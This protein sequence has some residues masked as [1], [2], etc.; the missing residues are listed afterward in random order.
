MIISSIINPSCPIPKLSGGESTVGGGVGVECMGK[1][2][3]EFNE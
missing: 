2:Y 1:W 3:G